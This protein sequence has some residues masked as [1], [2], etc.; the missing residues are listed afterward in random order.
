M[1][2]RIFGAAGEV[3][4]SCY[5]LE[6]GDS[7]VLVDFGLHQGRNDD[8]RNREPFPVVPQSLTAVVLTHAHL[9]HTGRVPLLVKGGY[10][11]KVWCTLPTAE[12]TD[13]LWRDAARLMQEEAE[14]KTR[15]NRRKG[16]EDVEPLYSAEDVDQALG[17]L[18]PV[19]YD[20]LLEVAPNIRV[21]FRDAGHILGSSILEFWM[22]DGAQEVKVVFSGDLG[23]QETVMEK[24][25]A[26]IEDADYVVIESTYGDRLHKTNLESRDEFRDVLRQA[27]KSRG[28]VL[29]P[30]FVVDR[31]QRVL[32]EL[33]LL[34]Q[35]GDLPPD[36][37]VFF[38]SPMG[39]RATEI[40]RRHTDLLSSEI[41]ERIHKGT[42]PFALENLQYVAEPEASREINDVRHALVM[43]G[44]GMCTGGRIVHHLKHNLWNESCHVIFVGYQAQGT[45]GRR[46]VDGDKILRIAG[47]DVTVKAQ[48]HTINGFSAH[49]DRRD[50]LRWARN[51]RNGPLFI[52]THGE[53]KS[54]Q[55]LAEGL[56]EEG[57]RAEVPAVGQEFSLESGQSFSPAVIVSEAF[58]ERSRRTIQAQI[59]GD[60][61][62][63]ALS[64]RESGDSISDEMAG[65][66]QTSRMLLRLVR[67]QSAQEE[68]KAG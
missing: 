36:V 66:L 1:R 61:A 22:I 51:F 16:L 28:K 60:I 37:P 44:S 31:A 9:D 12:L 39:V 35:G 52:V 54:S 5:L 27:L 24:S 67:Q 11:G 2:L 63:L 18:V 29:I 33:M 49:A 58:A 53:S 56:K 47:E 65:L 19:G 13:V 59:L 48:L 7:R 10:G 57:F 40:Y 23:P 50:L 3:T 68:E 45:L 14:W 46:L 64:I 6:N 41:Q 30:T 43:A 4:G 25:P 42:D 34:R 8:D 32:Y 26:C 15:K 17:R 21:R 55:A 20:Q 62:D 38:D